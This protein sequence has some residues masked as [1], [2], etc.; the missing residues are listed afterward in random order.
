MNRR[1]ILLLAATAVLVAAL[2]MIWGV[3]FSDSRFALYS[4]E[5]R[6]PRLLSMVVVAFA[7][8]TASIVFQSIINN[9][10]VTPCLLGMNSLYTLLHTA[11]IFLAGSRSLLA[12]NKVVAFILDAAL[13]GVTATIIYSHLFKRT[14]YNVL[15][16][17]LIGTL[18]T[19][20]FSSIQNTLT[21]I[22]DP[23]EYDNLIVTLV[24][25]FNN[26]SGVVLAA[27]SGL[28]AAIILLLRRDIAVLNVIA[29]GRA[30]AMNL[31]VDY[32]RVIKRLL[33]GVVLAITVATA[34]AGPLSFM[35]LIVANLARQLM[36]T[37]R[38][39]YLLTASFLFAVILLAG[40]Q[41]AIEQ[42][43]S[44]TVPVSVFIT[45]AGGVYFLYL[46]M[47]QQK[48]S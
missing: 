19:S 31:G 43:F 27:A 12:T 41:L 44:Y 14:G 13:M 32:D 47:R 1:K 9:T 28:L 40:S 21:R 37:Y 11:V 22:M 17:L 42:V 30:Q 39:K 38:H 8:G 24:A 34:L 4:L 29:L 48:R 5:I 6:L 36:G 23:T 33:L 2:Y 3:N 35:G 10:L 26:G 7:I 18:L 16:V 25:S 46:I 20:L 15:Y 45:L